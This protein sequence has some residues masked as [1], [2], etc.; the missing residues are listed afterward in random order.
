M[1]IT[2]T[3]MARPTETPI[4]TATP[5]ETPTDTPV[6]TLPLPIQPSAGPTATIFFPDKAD[7]VSV[8]PSPNLFTPGQTFVLTWQIKNIGISNWSGKYSFRHTDGVR[9]S[10]QTE[11]SINSIVAPNDTLTIS[12]PSTAPETA[13]NYQT[14]WSIVNP[15]GIVF[16]NVYYNFTVGDTTYITSIPTGAVTATPS[17]LYWMCT[18]AERSKVQGG[19]CKD[20]CSIQTINTLLN[21]GLTCY[22]AGLKVEYSN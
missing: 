20:Y 6:P 21:E 7:F 4:P 16:Y 2:G 1:I 3:W 8:L 11:Y 13:G 14:T 19:G 5:T 9:L 17:S 12:L 15:D 22:S 18:D 10:T